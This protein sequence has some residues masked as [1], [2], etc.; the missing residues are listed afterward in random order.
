MKNTDIITLK[1]EVEK[2][3]IEII[4]LS[5]EV[6]GLQKLNNWYAEQFKLAQH[7]RFGAS[8]EKSVFPEQLS[9]FNEAEVLADDSL[10]EPTLEETITY[11]RIKRIGKRDEIYADLPTEQRVHELPECP[12]T[13]YNTLLTT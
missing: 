6:V 11:Q 5:N 7:L 3:K 4:K 8:G 9:L 2:L 1:V 13:R 10:P 12:A